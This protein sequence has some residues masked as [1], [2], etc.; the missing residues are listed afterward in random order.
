MRPHGYLPTPATHLKLLRPRPTRDLII[1]LRGRMAASKGKTH[2]SRHQQRVYT[3][4]RKNFN[5][6]FS[7]GGFWNA[8]QST[9][10]TCLTQTGAEFA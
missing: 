4:P 5:P 8:R 6:I 10:C 3:Q 7:P 1:L 9:Y 2:G